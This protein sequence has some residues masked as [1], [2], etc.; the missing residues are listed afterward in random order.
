MSPLAI[1]TAQLTLAFAALVALSHVVFAESWP[2]DG[3]TAGV[4]A[5]L[6]VTLQYVVFGPGRVVTRFRGATRARLVTMGLATGFASGMPGLWLGRGFLAH[7]TAELPLGPF[8]A[9]HL[10]TALLFD[11]A[12]FLVVFGVSTTLVHHLAADPSPGGRG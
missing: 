3:F 1:R 11:V 4:I 5:A 9:L 8:G 2:G 12:I 7:V 6:G 10:S